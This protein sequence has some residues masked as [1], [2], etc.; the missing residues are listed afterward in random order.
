VVVVEV[1]P[2]LVIRLVKVEPLI[3]VLLVE[4]VVA[5][6]VNF[7]VAEEV[8]LVVMVLLVLVHKIFLE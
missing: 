4:I 2:A 3:K 6:V 7:M 8:A 5:A 1:T